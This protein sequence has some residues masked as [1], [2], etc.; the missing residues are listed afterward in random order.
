MSVRQKDKSI[1]PN[2]DEYCFLCKQKGRYVKGTDTH[3]CLF[4]NKK[5]YA[6]DDGLTVQLCHRCHMRLHQ[7]QEHQ[8]ELKR[9]A[10]QVWLDHYGKTVEDWISRYG[11]NFLD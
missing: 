11:K 8:L 4:G 10:E 6:D 5:K 2:N 9:L 1:I 3:H 7:Q